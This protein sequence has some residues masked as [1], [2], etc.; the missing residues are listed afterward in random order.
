MYWFVE[1]DSSGLQQGFGKAI[2]TF[3]QVGVPL[4]V[5]SLQ[6]AYLVNN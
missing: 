3:E 4:L 6:G 5:T 2:E 1:G